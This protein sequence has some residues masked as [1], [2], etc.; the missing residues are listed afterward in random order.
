MEAPG[1]FRPRR[2]AGNANFVPL[3]R[4]PKGALVRVT[5]YGHFCHT[6]L[7]ST[8]IPAVVDL[9]T[10]DRC[11]DPFGG[12]FAWSGRPV[13]PGPAPPGAP[14]GTAQIRVT[15][16]TALSWTG[17][18]LP[19]GK[20]LVRSSLQRPPRRGEAGTL[21]A[22]GDQRVHRR[23]RI[24]RHRP[25]QQDAHGQRQQGHGKRRTGSGEVLDTGARRRCG[26]HAPIRPAAARAG[27]GSGTQTHGSR[28]LR[29]GP[30]RPHRAA[31]RLGCLGGRTARG[32]RSGAL[33]LS[34]SR[35]RGW[36]T[37]QVLW[38]AVSRW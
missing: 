38:K 33:A 26:G 6:R 23:H 37:E 4:W 25:G 29:S 13:H 11:T 34:T 12:P 28:V 14:S 27:I 31:V 19:P 3:S 21:T 32:R 22:T 18:P 2:R 15:E 30:A 17:I 9:S 1:V 8:R 5:K 20:K 7:H 35:R 36:R 10:V 16:Q 24:Q